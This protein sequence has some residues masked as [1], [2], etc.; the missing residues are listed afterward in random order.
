MIGIEIQKGK[1]SKK[2]V[3]VVKSSIHLVNLNSKI[4]SNK[5]HDEDKES[6]LF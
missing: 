6:R 3:D 2:N 5:I 1:G 4:V